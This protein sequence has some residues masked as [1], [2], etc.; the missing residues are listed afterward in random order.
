MKPDSFCAQDEQV[1]FL[2]SHSPKSPSACG[3]LAPL[4]AGLGKVSTKWAPALQE[5]EDGHVVKAAHRLPGRPDWFGHYLMS[6]GALSLGQ[7]GFSQ[8]LTKHSVSICWDSRLVEMLIMQKGTTED[9][10][11]PIF[12]KKKKKST[13]R[14]KLE[15]MTISALNLSVPCFLLVEIE[16]NYFFS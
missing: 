12:I 1:S 11:K 4:V 15:N 13:L 8:L 9:T 7:L 10:G 2:E 3:M 14:S 6:A 5:T 16:T